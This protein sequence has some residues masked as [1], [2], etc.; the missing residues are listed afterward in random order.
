MKFVDATLARRLEASE[1]EAQ[2]AI[3]AVLQRR[4]PSTGAAVFDVGDG[5]A[6]F[7]GK[8][9]PV[10]RTIGYGFDRA[11]TAADIDAVEA[12][13][14]SH[15]VPA[16]FDVTPLQH[17][18]LTAL[19]YERGYS[20]LEL[21]N[22]MARELRREENWSD[23]VSCI[24]FRDCSPDLAPLWAETM[25]RGFFPDGP[26]PDW[27]EFVMPM[28]LAPNC[29]P[30]LAY[31]DGKPVAAASGLIYP[32]WRMMM[33][34]GTSTLPEY[35]GRGIQTAA[36]GRR[37]NRAVAAGCDIAVVVTRG[38]TASQRNAERLGFTLAYSKATLVQPKK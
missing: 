8:G 10:G 2:L 18:S 19:L 30:L 1:D 6:V 20:M 21:N 32:Q 16:Q 33:L 28:A 17:E 9:S 35:R 3:S 5:H 25:M 37:L 31:A 23:A 26:V 11:A 22:V 29:L 12:F 34:G 36:I 14:A 7:A 27:H 24:E 4:N 38:G 13:Y 15:G